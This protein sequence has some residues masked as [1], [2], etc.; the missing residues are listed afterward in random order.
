MSPAPVAIERIRQ[1]RL[2][3]VVPTF[4][5]LAG[6]ASAVVTIKR[7]VATDT[8]G[9]RNAHSSTAR[10]SAEGTGLAGILLPPTARP[11]PELASRQA[12]KGVADPERAGFRATA[13]SGARVQSSVA[14]YVP[15]VAAGSPITTSTKVVRKS[16][17]HSNNSQPVPQKSATIVKILTVQPTQPAAAQP[18]ANVA[19]GGQYCSTGSV[20]SDGNTS[21]GSVTSGSCNNTSTT[22]G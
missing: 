18:P 17:Q 14:S 1:H 12:A 19:S 11:S 6:F 10:A 20:Q 22:A 21:V 2:W 13:P 7:E 8:S 16:V 4:L 9:P 5:A 15:H 3:W